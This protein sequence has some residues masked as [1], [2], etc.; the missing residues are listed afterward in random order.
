MPG[1]NPRLDA[2]HPYPFEKLRQLLAPVASLP[3]GVSA[4]NLSIGE[5][6]HAAPARVERALADSMSG[7]SVYPPTKGDPALRR[8]IAEWLAHRYSIPAPDLD[9]QV[10]PVTGSRE[11]LFS[12]VQAMLDPDAAGYVISPNPFYQIYEGAALLAGAKTYFV[13][14]DA[15]RNFSCDWD[16][17]PEAIWQDT[18]LV[19]VCSPG[20]PAGNVIEQEEWEKLFQLSDR[21]GFIIASDECYSEIYLDEHAPPI[22]GLQAA[23]RLERADFRNLVVFGSLSKRSNMPGLRSGYVAG[24]AAL[25]AKFLHYR[26]YH[27]CAMSPLVSAASIAAWTDETHVR[28]N[29]RMYR[30]KFDAVVPLLKP[31]LDVR[32]PEASFYLWAGVRGSDTQYTRELY[33]HTGVTVL[34]GSFLAREAQGRNP[35]A[36]RVRIAL[37]A[38][39][40]QCVEAAHRMVRFNAIY[41]G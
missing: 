2:L 30:E 11:A 23:K 15:E 27:G 8:V 36:G 6:K 19:F 1:M 16:S 17:V 13:N 39:L 12:F 18:K 38:P 41:T 5:P 31:V 10:L 20:N 40:A 3:P 26:T 4:I 34:P 22:G 33:A 25:L 37:V 7:L 24:D 21:Y 32:K 28:D 35:G 9:S 29:R 14:A